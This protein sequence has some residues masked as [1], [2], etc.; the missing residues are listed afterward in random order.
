[1][2]TDQHGFFNAF[3]VK[4]REIRVIRV[5]NHGDSREPQILVQKA[6]I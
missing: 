2:D 6:S 5:Q 3:S 1:M 4:L